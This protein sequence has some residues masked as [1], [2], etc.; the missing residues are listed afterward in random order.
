MRA[1]LG[2]SLALVALLGLSGA[3]RAAEPGLESGFIGQ[4][5]ILTIDSGGHMSRIT[6]L[7]FTHDGHGLVSVGDDKIIRVWS[8]DSGE[9]V[10][11][12]RG[13]IRPGLQ[14]EIYA[15]ALSPDDRYLAVGG[16][17]SLFGSEIRLYNF[18]TG[19]V[20][21]V[22]NGHL[23]VINALAFSPDGRM[24]ASAS[25]DKTV[26]LW[27][28]SSR[29]SLLVL[30]HDDA[31]YTVAFS[32]DGTRVVSGSW[33]WTVRLWDAKSGALIRK[34][35][36]HKDKVRSTAFSADGRYI[37]SGSDDKSVRL[38]DAATGAF[39]KELSR[40][41]AGVYGLSFTPDSQRL[42]VENVPRRNT[43]KV[44]SVPEGRA[45]ASFEKHDNR[46]IAV[47]VSPDGKVA[48]TGGG[49]DRVIYLWDLATGSVIRK[50]AGSGRH[51][52]SVG[53][54]SD[55][56]SIAFGTTSHGE[57]M[58]LLEP[59]EQTLVIDPELGISLSGKVADPGTY[60]RAVDR[61]GVYQLKTKTGKF[62]A[63]LQILRDGEV[64]REITRDGTDGYSHRCITWT[65][66]G[67]QFVSGGE[68]GFLT[69]YDGVTGQAVRNFVGHM[70]DVSA[71]AVSPDGKRLV[72]GSAD[73]TVRLWDLTTGANLLTVFAAT[74]GEWVAWT[75]QGF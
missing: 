33:D 70:G 58:N 50:L 48:A 10:R 62:E 6:R 35:E 49:S 29:Q 17:F 52:W 8:V 24:L 46:A 25:F 43:Y 64:I 21:A 9:T 1:R 53:F 34:M 51:V 44:I 63:V 47:A 65:P 20:V 14:G 4:A 3:G 55:G 23:N 16:Y 40:S 30:R 7:V 38:W 31:V 75:P 39:V 41:D 22:L 73:Q 11:T 2:G 67:K 26:H 45:L 68:N 61:F 18:Q 59:L 36:G 42:L 72:S 13:Q 74:D 60:L 69:L 15:A 5:P 28:V 56:R 71:V 12:L 66:D 54:A 32:P 27:D 19:E 57:G 37:A